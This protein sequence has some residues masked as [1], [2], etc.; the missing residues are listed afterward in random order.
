MQYSI[1]KNNQLLQ[2]L[3][4]NSREELADNCL[5]AN[6]IEYF[7]HNHI[8]IIN[9]NTGWTGYQ[10]LNISQKQIAESFQINQS[11]NAITARQEGTST[12]GIVSCLHQAIFNDNY[13][14]LIIGGKLAYGRELLQKVVLSDKFEAT[15]I[16]RNIDRIEF[17]NGSS[18]QIYGTNE[19]NLRGKSFHMVWF[20]NTDFI[21]NFSE[22]YSSTRMYQCRDYKNTKWLFTSAIGDSCN[23][24]KLSLDTRIQTLVL[25][26]NRDEESKQHILNSMGRERY[27]REYEC[28]FF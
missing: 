14:I 6:S 21:D 8:K 1:F 13:R 17:S 20:D 5:S 11:T 28:R 18:I 9:P 3:N 2:I 19:L 25:P 22:L 26:T 12:I 27:I 7:F 15:V 10:N 23:S 24:L 4:Q 16:K